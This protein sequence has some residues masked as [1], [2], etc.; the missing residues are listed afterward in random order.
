[1]GQ[2]PPKG[3]APRLFALRGDA[4][5]LGEA[6]KLL[7]DI[8]HLKITLHAAADRLAELRFDGMLDDEGHTA[9]ARPVCVIERIIND[10]AALVVHRRHL[11]HAAEAAA[12]TGCQNDKNRL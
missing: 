10:E 11:L 7:K 2:P 8:I 9:E 12:H 6:V 4:V 1:M 5:A 3:A